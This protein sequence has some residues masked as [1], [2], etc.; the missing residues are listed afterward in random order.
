MT[1]KAIYEDGVFKP[2]EPVPL[3]DH[4]EVELEIRTTARLA[5]GEG[6]PRRFIGFIKDAPEGVP[7]AAEHDFYLDMEQYGHM[8]YYLRPLMAAAEWEE[9]NQEEKLGRFIAACKESRPDLND[10]WEGMDR[11]PFMWSD[12]LEHCTR[13][14]QRATAAAAARR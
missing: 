12:A 9:L 14:I 3:E 7:L 5:A 8:T 10:L 11:H 1:V 13:M 6:D 2:K 4:A